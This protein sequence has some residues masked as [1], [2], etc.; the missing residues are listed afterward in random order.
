MLIPFLRGE[1]E[2]GSQQPRVQVQLAVFEHGADLDARLAAALV[3]LE[4]LAGLDQ[5]PVFVFTTG[6]A[7]EGALAPAFL[8]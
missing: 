7:L 1:H 4:Q 3:A 6:G 2:V 8:A 5:S